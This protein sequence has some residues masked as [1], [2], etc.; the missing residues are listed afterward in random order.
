MWLICYSIF[1]FS[2]GHAFMFRTYKL[3][4]ANKQTKIKHSYFF[5][6]FAKKEEHFFSYYPWLKKKS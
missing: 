4:K 3:K 6:N 1:D 2:L 5:H